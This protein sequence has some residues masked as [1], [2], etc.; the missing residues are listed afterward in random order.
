LADIT[1]VVSSGQPEPAARD[2]SSPFSTVPE[3]EAATGSTTSP[4]DIDQPIQAW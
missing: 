1:H 4:S 3:E 2:A